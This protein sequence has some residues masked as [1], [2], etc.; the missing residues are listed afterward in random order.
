M[1]VIQINAQ[2]STPPGV[3]GVVRNLPGDAPII[4]MIHGYRYS[5]SDPRH[6]PHQHILA[7]DP[8]QD[9]P[10]V[11]SWP[12]A[13]GFGNG[14]ADAGLAIALGWEARGR[15]GTAFGRAADAGSWLGAYLSEF[16]D[17]AGRPVSII[18]HSMGARVALQ[19]LHC[20]APGSI[21]RIILLAGAEF[22]DEAAAAIRSPAGKLAE[23]IN[24]TSR[25][26]DLFDFGIE[27]WLGRGRKRALGFGLKEPTLNWV[28]LQIDCP[29]NLQ[30]LDRMGFDIDRAPLRLSHWSPYM[31]RGL[32]D[33]YRTA[34]RQ[35]WA[36]PLAMLRHR[37][38]GPIAPRWSRLFAPPP[39]SG[40]LRA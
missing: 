24:V 13:L 19:S 16:A 1:P 7:L 2:Q 18:G 3:R 33:F 31:R 38:Q 14:A 37:L 6:D 35:P 39:P 10:R 21:G 15:L 12:R 5:P 9:A 32:F 27:L 30:A 22:E 23:V 20:A 11:L 4:V 29:E 34:L 25:E 8:A 26:N 28:D 40:G 17:A 36:L